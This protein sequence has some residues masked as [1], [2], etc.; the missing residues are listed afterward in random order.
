M[1]IPGKTREKT[2]AWAE[3]MEKSG[4]LK[5]NEVDSGGDSLTPKVRWNIG[6]NKE[7]ADILNNVAVLPFRSA[8]LSTSTRI[9]ELRESTMG[10]EKSAKLVGEV[11]PP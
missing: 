5:V 11:L 4:R 1:S 10:G 3:T 6:G 7:S 9:E 2:L 8:I